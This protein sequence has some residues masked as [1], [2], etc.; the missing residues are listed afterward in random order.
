[1]FEKLLGTKKKNGNFQFVPSR[2]WNK[3]LKLFFFFFFLS[4]PECWKQSAGLWWVDGVWCTGSKG[5]SPLRK[6]G[7]VC[8]LSPRR[9]S[10]LWSSNF[11]FFE[12]RKSS[13]NKQND[14]WDLI[15]ATYYSWHPLK[16]FPPPPFFFFLLSRV[17]ALK[18][19]PELGKQEL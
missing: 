17:I 1:M 12:K 13:L 16:A 4:S 7:T 19:K 8:C 11:C 6:T 9:V 18:F 3:S 2:S 10:E 15:T 5:V 14:P